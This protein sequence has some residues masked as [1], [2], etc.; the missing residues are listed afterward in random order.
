MKAHIR[1][2][3]QKI[4]K[5][6]ESDNHIR[7]DCIKTFLG[8]EICNSRLVR[9]SII[10]DQTAQD[11][12]EFIS[13]EELDVSVSQGNGSA[14]GMDG[15]NNCFIK[16][17]W[18]LLRIPLH[19]YTTCC[20]QKGSLTQ[21]FRTASIKLI[22]KKGDCTKIKNW[23]PISLLS[24]LYKVISR[25]L[26]NRLKK[27][28]GIIF[29]RG[30]KGFT[31]DRHIQEVLMNIVEMIAHCK[32][33]NIPV[34]ILSIDTAKAFD[35]VS[36]RYMHLV[37]TF[38]GFGPNFIK[39]METLGNNRT[40]CIAFDDGSH[41][42]EIELECGRAQGNTSSPV[43]YNMAQQI[44][45]FKIEL[46]PQVRSVYLNHFI[47]RPYLPDPVPETPITPL[48]VDS[49]AQRFRNES[50]FET[51]KADGF[52]DDNTTGTIFEYNY[53]KKIKDILTDF[54]EISGLRCNTEKTALMQIGNKIP[55]SQEIKDLGFDIT[56]KVHILGMDIDSEAE[57]LDENFVGT[58]ASL[59]KCIDYWKRYNLTMVGR[60]LLF[61]QILYLGSFLMPSP[62]KLKQ[63]QKLLDDFALGDTKIARD[64]IKLP[65]E[66]GGLG[67]F[68]VEKFLISQQA[69]WVLK[70][71][72]SSRD[73]WRYKLRVL[74]NGNV[75]CAGP[76]LIKKS[77]NPI[78]YGISC[79]FQKVKLS[80]DCLNSNFTNALILN[81]PIFFRGPGNK[82]PL[83]LS[84]LGLSE[85]GASVMASLSARNFFNVNSIKTRME[86]AF[87][88]NLQIGIEGYANLALCLNHYVRRLKTNERNDGSSISLSDEFCSLKKPGKKLRATLVKKRRK[89]FE[90]R[91]QGTTVTFMQIT[92]IE[93]PGEKQ[94]GTIVS[95]WNSQG[96]P[97]RVRVFLFKFFNNILGI[98]TRL[99]HFVPNQSRGCTFCHLVGTNPLPDETFAHIF[100][101][102]ATVRNWHK[103]FI[104]DYFPNGY[105][106]DEQDRKNILFFR[107]GSRTRL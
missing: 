89:K 26:N 70:A 107:Q 85:S 95:L 83:N 64:R 48:P 53:L 44:V 57:A 68:D 38:F 72:K 39:L 18:H 16:K 78:L 42:A 30:Q 15:I 71:H 75:L 65:V 73:N 2:F 8:E 80:H 66:M 60:I 94:Y 12:E 97:N 35:S 27:V 32:E 33:Y 93:F 37:Y 104:N 91:N 99:S 51:S 55:I 98:N 5:K 25:A 92:G 81:N 13:I 67:L 11:F 19:R 10:P 59:K 43:E 21:S 86:L 9:D 7:D 69:S 3:Y 23:R 47:A 58:V 4:Y 90:H 105:L 103:G 52:A 74:C 76:A 6:P 96:L 40:A 1:N 106:V 34:A 63:M 87:D 56:N 41:S 49:D 14:A 100:F 20:H 46:C 29:S 79:S 82:Q 17:F 62:E 28:S 36:H 50:T 101:E 54:A 45:L 84:Y 61:S 77:A 88:Y 102:C 31:K 24:C 22:P